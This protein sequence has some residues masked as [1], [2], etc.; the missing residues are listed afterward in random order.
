M[1]DKMQQ[2]L[3]ERDVPED[4]WRVL[5]QVQLRSSRHRPGYPQRLSLLRP[6][7]QPSWPTKV[8]LN[9][10]TS[11]ADLLFLLSNYNFDLLCTGTSVNKMS[12]RILLLACGRQLMLIILFCWDFSLLV[13]RG[14]RIRPDSSSPEPDPI[15]FF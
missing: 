14:G 15:Q 12:L 8:P 3:E 4:V 11:H 2:E 6:N 9:K 10:S 13:L 5:L 7:A 1:P